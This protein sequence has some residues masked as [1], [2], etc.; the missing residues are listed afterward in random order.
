MGTQ[1][2]FQR[3][4]SLQARNTRWALQYMSVCVRDSENLNYLTAQDEQTTKTRHRMANMM[5]QYA[6]S[7]NSQGNK[8]FYQPD[9]D[10][11]IGYYIEAH[12]VIGWQ[13]SDSYEA[14][15]AYIKEMYR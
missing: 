4:A 5:K 12:E 6:S 8:V 14:V 1:Q 13:T 9:I 2:H 7:T 11:F 10:T 15:H 3:F